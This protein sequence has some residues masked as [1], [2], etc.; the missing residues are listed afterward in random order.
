MATGCSPNSWPFRGLRSQL[1]LTGRTDDPPDMNSSAILV[2]ALMAYS[3]FE[4][5]EGTAT[6]LQV[7]LQPRSCTVE[8]DGRG[9]GL[10]REGYVVGLLEQLTPRRNEVALHGIGLA[11][12]AMSSPLLDI[13]SRRN[14]RRWTQSFAWGEAQGPVRSEPMEGP[15]GTRVTFTLPA[16]APAIDRGGVLAQVEVW[17]AAHPALRI[18]VV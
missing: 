9:M 2:R 8:D 13:E 16:D 5:Q 18:D 6:R 12:I 7:T 11:I 3:V 15:T 14:G 10:D 4:H 17:R 1:A